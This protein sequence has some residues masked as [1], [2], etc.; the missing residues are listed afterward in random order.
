MMKTRVF[1][2]LLCLCLICLPLLT[3]CGEAAESGRTVTLYVYNWGEYISDG[4]EDTRDV[5]AE[6]EDYC[7]EV[8]GRNVKVNYST[9]SSN[10]DMYA[11]VSSGAALYDVIIPSD[12][13]I[14]RMIGE[15][16]LRPLNM[17]NIPHY[18]YI[19]DDFKGEN[20]YYEPAGDA[21]YSVPYFYGQIGILYNTE[22]VSE[23]AE[24]FGTW[25]LMWDEDYKGEILQINNSRDAFGSA[26]YML[27]YGDYINKTG[28]EYNQYWQEALDKLK[29]QKKLVQGYVMDEVF[30]K[31]K[32]GSASIAA[33]YAGD[34]L[35]MYEEND[36]LGFYY[37]REGTNRYV[38]AMCVPSNAK[39]PEL[40][41]LYI[42]FMC[43]P[44]VALANAAYTYY[45][46]PLDFDAIEAEG[47]EDYVAALDEYRET[48]A[49]VHE[50]AIEILYGD[51]A[52]SVPTWPYMNLSPE[53]LAMLND[54]WE[55]LKVE[56]DVSVGIIVLASVILAAC[57]GLV[58]FYV[59]RSRRRK[60]WRDGLW[61]APQENNQ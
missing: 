2:L 21:I 55:E 40:A 8:L 32:S 3:A 50:D 47:N 31:M 36:A 5:N 44:D 24:T 10:E 14:E 19:R 46:S 23:D 54:L 39:N 41:E 9:F 18:A 7:R 38:D 61:T 49:E 11:K 22:R 16:R 34:F 42:N 4:Y 20:V 17:E 1:A 15:E 37:P 12:Y 56:S 27:G 6:F 59:V 13:M 29:E 53:G 60:K 58:I 45:A 26:F 25:A 43:R 57:A 51:V 52:S 35:S 30:Y 33:Y 48:M 28:P